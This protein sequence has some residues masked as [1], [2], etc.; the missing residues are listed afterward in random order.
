[1]ILVQISD[2]HIRRP[3]KLAYQ[4]V[5]TAAA[6]SLVVQS[7]EALPQRADAVVI[8]GDLVDFGQA[9]EYEH[10]RALLAPLSAPVYLLAGNHDDR[11]MLRS[12]FGDHR[13]LPTTGRLCY[14][15]DLAPLRL[16]ALDSTVPG[17]SHGALDGAQLDW[18]D[19]EL[20][21]APD[22]P[23]LVALHHPPFATLIGHMDQVGL[24]EGAAGLDAVIRRHPQVERVICGHLHR[25]IDRRF[26]GTIASTCP[27]TSHQV[28]LDL[29]P[30][31]RSRFAMEPPAFRVHA[32]SDVSGLV[33]HLMPVGRFEGPFPFY[34]ENGLID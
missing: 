29:S 18:L 30:D 16:I 5:D 19:T 34:D 10:L 12:V 26:A 21:R 17:H 2:P 1:M 9:E 11:N 24:R 3:G 27:G 8:T 6:L 33:S 23:T 7:I 15:V 14:A 13:Y 22:K 32:W 31:A 25:A 4:K 20:A 28:C